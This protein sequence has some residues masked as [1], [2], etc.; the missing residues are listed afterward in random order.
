MRELIDLIQSVAGTALKVVEEG[1]VRPNEMDDVYA[2][3]EKARDLRGW[4]PKVSL[5]EGLER[6]MLEGQVS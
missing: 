2:D 1:K 4:V 3:I 5:R 6:M